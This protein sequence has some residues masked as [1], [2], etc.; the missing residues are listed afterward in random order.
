MKKYEGVATITSCTLDGKGRF[1]AAE[2]ERIIDHQIA[3]G[4]KLVQGPLIDELVELAPGEYRLALKVLAKATKG[5]ALSIANV[6]PSPD[7]NQTIANAKECAECGVDA[8]KIL[9]PLYVTP[10][11][12][13][14]DLYTY[15][16]AVIRATS[17]LVVIYNQPSRTLINVAPET[18]ARL[19]E[20]FPQL[21]MVQDDISQLPAIKRRLGDRLSVGVKFP[22]WV[23]SHAIGG[24]VFYSRVPYA[25]L[26]MHELYQL[27]AKSDYLAARKMFYDRYDLYQLSAL[28]PGGKALRLCLK[29]AGFDA[30]DSEGLPEKVHQ[31]ITQAIGKHLRP[32]S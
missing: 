27:C 2:Y 32:K 6:C 20:A 10:E 30:G 11:L 29:Q 31:Q 5:K 24:E 19:A 15:F 14:D 8:L 21:V 28:R 12:T 3:N 13:Q 16:S 22:Y 17:C 26:A 9:T 7:I 4:V 25:P 18:L 1:N 23:A